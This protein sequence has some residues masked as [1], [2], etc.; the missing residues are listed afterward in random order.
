VVVSF[1]PDIDVEGCAI[2]C[3]GACKKV[4]P[5]Q[6]FLCLEESAVFGREVGE[7]QC[8]V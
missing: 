1:A 8:I 5:A 6:E 2:P 3:G 4:I 7:R